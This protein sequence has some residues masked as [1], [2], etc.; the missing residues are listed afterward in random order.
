MRRLRPAFVLVMVALLLTGLGCVQ[1]APRETRPA[2]PTGFGAVMPDAPYSGYIYLS[3]ERVPFVLEHTFVSPDGVTFP[4]HVEVQTVSAWLGPL[5]GNDTPALAARIV[6]WR[7][8]DARSAR[9][10]LTRAITGAALW[11]KQDGPALYLVTGADK[12]ADALREALDHERFVELSATRA[13][14]WNTVLS[15]PVHPS[16]PVI[17]A[18]YVE[19]SADLFPQ[20]FGTL[21]AQG[22]PDLRKIQALVQRARIGHLAFGIYGDQLPPL[23]PRTGLGDL[24][25]S[26]IGAI[27]VADTAIP[28]PLLSLT[29]NLAGRQLGLDRVY[30]PDGRAFF[31]GNQELVTLTRAHGESIYTAAA[32]SDEDAREL[33][34]RLGP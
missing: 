14:A 21:A 23:T 1:A 25:P 8:E 6:F 20:S 31:Y 27:A 7:E 30:L 10:D 22:G 13:R 2:L 3:Q 32:F 9:E 17:G 4:V 33:L 24:A 12:H 11:T 26:H 16:K 5:E 34:E 29:F 28:A 18:G 19:V 15:L